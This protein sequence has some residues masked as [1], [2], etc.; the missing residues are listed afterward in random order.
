MKYRTDATVSYDSV[1][2][3]VNL[4]LKCQDIEVIRQS[5]EAAYK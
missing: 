1:N 4:V 5:T 3:V 2:A